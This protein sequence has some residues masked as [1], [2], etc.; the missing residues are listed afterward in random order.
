M[1]T[2]PA[3][4]GSQH[5]PRHNRAAHLSRPV[6][7]GLL[8]SPHRWRWPCIGWRQGKQLAH[9]DAEG[10]RQLVED[11]NGRVVALGFNLTDI[12]RI[13]AGIDS[14]ALLRQ[15]ARDADP[16]EVPRS[17]SAIHGPQATNWA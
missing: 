3:C 11:A 10:A 4:A 8:A 1:V 9:I 2:L 17:L 12:A 13:D 15:P 16:S 6:P 14:K 7:R 5:A